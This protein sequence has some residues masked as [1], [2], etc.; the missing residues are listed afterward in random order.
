MNDLG[1]YLV[2]QDATQYDE[3]V[4]LQEVLKLANDSKVHEVVVLLDSC[5]SG[6][7]GNVPVIDKH[8]AVHL[9][10]V[11]NIAHARCTVG[12]R[13]SMGRLTPPVV[14]GST[15]RGSSIIAGR[16]GVASSSRAAV[17]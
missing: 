17:W 1:G 4:A 7:M 3:G 8:M 9:S 5:F 2:T 11:P 15:S 12:H 6:A 14:A 10:R 16:S 13:G